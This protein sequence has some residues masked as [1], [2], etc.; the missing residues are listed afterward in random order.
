MRIKQVHIENFRSL[1]DVTIDFDNVTTFIGPNGVGKSTVLRALEWFFSPI[2]KSG[3][4]DDKDVS[5]GCIG[6]NVRVEVRFSQLTADDRNELGSYAPTDVD[7]F[8]AWKTRTPD[9][10]EYLSANAKSFELFAKV[11]EP[12]LSATDKRARYKEVRDGNPDL[13]LATAT[14]GT[15]VDEAM[16]T[17][18]ANNPELLTDADE[19]LQTNFF[20]FNSNGKMSGLFDYVLITA[21]LRA[22]EESSDMKSSIIGRILERAVDRSSADEEITKIVE[23]SRILQQGVYAARF[24]EPLKSLAERLNAVVETYSPGRSVQVTPAEVELK[25]PRTTFNVTIAD[26]DIETTIDRQGHGFQRTVLISSLQMLAEDGAAS[27]KGTIFLAIEEPELFQ[28]PVQAQA[29]A[30]ILR[31]LA[32]NTGKNIQV[33]YATHSPYFIDG[34]KFDQIR[35][36]TRG[37]QPDRR[38]TVHACSLSKIEERLS[39]VVTPEQVRKQLEGVVSSRLSSAVF[40]NA[41]LIVEGTTDGAIL[42]GVADR[43]ATGR[44]EASGVAVVPAG[45]KTS[46]ALPHAILTCMGIPTY[47]V[48]DADAGVEDRAVQDGKSPTDVR[49][50][51]NN[52][53]KMNRNNLKYF[54]LPEVDIPDQQVTDHVAIVGDHIEALLDQEWLEWR[55]A[56]NVHESSTGE[57]L[58]KNQ[59][60]YRVVTRAAAGSPPEILSSILVKTIDLAA[61]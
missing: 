26:G 54:G 12:G 21:D 58:A 5:N 39:G 37:P 22:S 25:A 48:F 35:R 3:S 33:S 4:L 59:A 6:E 31:S 40:A 27:A 18:E 43:Q 20:G 55:E 24:Q 14:S 15:A 61:N 56:Y 19:E 23:Q 1:K 51:V 45:G 2:A 13:S 32:E 49:N 53:H 52:N 42:E 44:M 7:S 47:S 41:A 9:G 50:D 10:K 60:G 28:H 34:S 30:K 16:R 17:F 46:L 57:V 11:R 8:A 38:V 29:F 36:L